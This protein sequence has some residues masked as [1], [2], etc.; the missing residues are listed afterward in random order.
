MDITN[1]SVTTYFVDYFQKAFLYIDKY[2]KTNLEKLANNNNSEIASKLLNISIQQAIRHDAYSFVEALIRMLY[3]EELNSG[4]PFLLD[5]K[6][7]I[8]CISTL[9]LTEQNQMVVKEIL[10]EIIKM[11]HR[12]EDC[13]QV[14]AKQ[15]QLLEEIEDM[16]LHPKEVKFFIGTNILDQDESGDNIDKKIYCFHAYGCK[17]L[18]IESS[19]NELIFHP[20][21]N[22]YY[23]VLP[24]SIEDCSPSGKT[25]VRQPLPSDGEPYEVRQIANLEEITSINDTVAKKED[26]D[27]IQDSLYHTPEDTSKKFKNDVEYFDYYKSKIIQEE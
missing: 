22:I 1:D 2:L 14:M 6:D 20:F 23:K 8:P 7:I 25:V 24:V 9:G 17:P 4:Y 12:F 16:V 3:Q 18:E 27:S 19:D 5:I 21:D 26:E 11:P 15:R 10:S 13:C